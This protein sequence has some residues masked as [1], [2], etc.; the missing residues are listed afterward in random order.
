MEAERYALPFETAR[1]HFE[2]GRRLP[3]GDAERRTHLALADAGFRQLK[4]A[5]EVKR[6]AEALSRP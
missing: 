6:V 4:A 5:A 2:I 1:A 3:A